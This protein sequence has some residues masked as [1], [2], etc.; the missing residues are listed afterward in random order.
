[1]ACHRDPSFIDREKTKI[2]D[3]FALTGQFML[4]GAYAGLRHC[5]LLCDIILN[6]EALKYNTGK[7]IPNQKTTFLSWRPS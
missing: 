6:V 4:I 5:A 1:M 7:L 2:N 3:K